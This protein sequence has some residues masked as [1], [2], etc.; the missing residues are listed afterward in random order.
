MYRKTC[1]LCQRTS[2]KRWFG[3]RTMTSNCDVTNSAQQI[4]MTTLCHSM[5]PP[6][7]KIFCVRHCLHSRAANNRVKAVMAFF[8]LLNSWK[9]FR[10]ARCVLWKHQQ[11]LQQRQIQAV[12]LFVS[13]YFMVRASRITFFKKNVF[14]A[15]YLFFVLFS[16]QF[17]KAPTMLVLKI[18]KQC[19]NVCFVNRVYNSM[20]SIRI[21]LTTAYLILL[22]IIQTTSPTQLSR[23]L[24][25]KQCSYKSR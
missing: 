21:K 25:T 18:C 10:V 22:A 13:A 14:L 1:I 12:L 20:L 16:L 7:M 24:A 4:Q 6:P 9:T 3:N 11:F 17:H 15:M 2:L 23:L 5:N 19:I 8:L